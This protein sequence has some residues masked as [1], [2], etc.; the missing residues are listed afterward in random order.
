MVGEEE[1]SKSST[2]SCTNSIVGVVEIC[3]SFAS[4]TKMLLVSMHVVVDQ[5]QNVV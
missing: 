4:G 3:I 2:S 1:G 5:H